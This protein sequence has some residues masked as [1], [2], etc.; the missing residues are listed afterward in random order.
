MSFFM[1][2]SCSQDSQKL[3]FEIEEKITAALAKFQAEIVE[4]RLQY[5][6]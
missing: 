5:T 6:P 3:S 2:N 1:K 4:N